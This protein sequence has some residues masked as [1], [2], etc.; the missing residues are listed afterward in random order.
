MTAGVNQAELKL[1]PKSAKI[2]E[3]FAFR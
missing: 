3:Y 2:A 1:S